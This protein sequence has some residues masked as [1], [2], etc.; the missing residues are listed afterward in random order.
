M[1]G[2]L[3]GSYRIVEKIGEGGMGAVYRAVDEMLE[4]EVAVKAIRP[5]LTREPEIVERFRTE[6]K[7]LARVHHPAIATIYSFFHD[8]DELFL[9]MEYVRGR[10]LSEV[11][12]TGGALPWRRAVPLLVSALDG[13]EQAHRAGIV[14]RDLK[15][16]NLMLTEAGTLK[17]M[18]FGIARV[19]GSNHLTR[20]GLLVGTLRYVAPEQIRGEEVDRR[21]DVYAL[22]S[23]L[24]QMLTGRVPFDGPTDFAILKAQL[25]D[26]PV[27][28]GSVVTGVPE[29]L[30]RAVLKTLEKEPAARFQTVE[31]LRALL[32]REMGT[33]AA[34]TADATEELPTLIL[35]PRPTPPPV[36]SP[37]TIETDRPRLAS[38]PTPP[39]PPLPPLPVMS[40]PVPVA[41]A[42]TS[43][44][45]VEAP[46]GKKGL[47][48][49]ALVLVLVVAG[50]F[51]WR[52]QE[53]PQ[54]AAGP[55]APPASVPTGTPAQVSAP[56]VPT[57]V[58]AAP[59]T[60]NKADLQPS[61]PL[62]SSKQERPRP[63]APTPAPQTLPEPETTERSQPPAPAEP[64]PTVEAPAPAEPSSDGEF[65]IDE[66]RRLGGELVAESGHLIEV[67]ET[68]L[69]E[70]EDGGAEITAADEKLQEEMEALLETAE[71]FNKR[72]KDGV[73]GRNKE[74]LKTAEGRDEVKRRAREMALAAAKV[75]ALMAETR[76]GP[77]VKQS[78]QE[79]RRRWERVARIFGVR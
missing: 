19:S 16:D 28:P 48:A 64:E 44:R 41:P 38:T 70:K 20:T 49:A 15:P 51:L 31:E 58:P 30:D 72:V 1:I 43:Y 32:V 14:H 9:A 53:E 69:E 29:W 67:Y 36:S 45:P 77:A 3:V 11:L 71:R 23:V 27:P 79:V 61:Q 24:Y 10:T 26:P 76:P 4:R 78:W 35:P 40:A 73:L 12:Q 66:L 8:G 60:E 46:G 74:R 33:A 68:F 18:D 56:L 54:P 37:E 17:V 47:I 7:I 6:A 25:E 62:P 75:E 42:G 55:A 50:V 22:G 5:A 63:A 39:P 57:P 65:P 34:T 13:I 52:R 21:T 2:R 59:A